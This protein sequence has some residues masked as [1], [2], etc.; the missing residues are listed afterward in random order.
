MVSVTQWTKTPKPSSPQTAE[1]V[2][3]F[4]QF[5]CE[6]KSG[7]FCPRLKGLG[8]RNQSA[9]RAFDLDRL[10]ARVVA[11]QKGAKPAPQLISI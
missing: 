11:L 2:G 4:P 1:N 7:D 3:Q 6:A 9:L 10:R 5:F 8:T